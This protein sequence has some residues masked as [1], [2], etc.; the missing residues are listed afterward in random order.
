MCLVARG[1]GR[2]HGR[3]VGGSGTCGWAT[4]SNT[5]AITINDGSCIAGNGS[6]AAATPYPSTIT[7][8]GLTGTITDVNVTLTGLSHTFPDDVGVLL[9]GPQGQ[10]TILMAD[11]G[12]GNGFSDVNLTFDDAA[13]ASLPD[14]EPMVSGTYRPTVGSAAGTGAASCTVPS[15]F[16]SPAPASPYGSSLSVFNGTDPN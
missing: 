13:A 2:R 11:T 15:S 4:F 1:G 3:V 10:S 6:A 8:S 12:D 9:V 14:A 7:V 16:P 5:G